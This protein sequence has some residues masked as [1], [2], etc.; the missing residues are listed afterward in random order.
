M[1]MSREDERK[2]KRDVGMCEAERRRLLMN[3]P[4]RLTGLGT[5]GARGQDV[6]GHSSKSENAAPAASSNCSLV[7]RPAA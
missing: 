3:R 7:S 2:K 6:N 4:R 5:L 1:V